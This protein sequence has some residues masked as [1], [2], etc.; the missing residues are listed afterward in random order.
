MGEHFPDTEGVGSSILPVPTMKE[1]S[2]VRADIKKCR[3]V[4]DQPPT[5]VLGSGRLSRVEM[6]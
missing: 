1:L 5:P 6:F 3:S 4:H 2:A